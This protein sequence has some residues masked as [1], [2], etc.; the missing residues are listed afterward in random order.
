[1]SQLHSVSGLIWKELK[2]GGDL[3]A[4]NLESSQASDTHMLAWA[5]MTWHLRAEGLRGVSRYD[6]AS[7]H[8]GAFG[9]VPASGLE[10]AY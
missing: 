8:H 7:L 10:T 3:T 9:G 4:G 5:G 2:T 1:M 6:W